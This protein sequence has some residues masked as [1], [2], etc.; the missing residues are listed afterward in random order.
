MERIRK[1]RVLDVGVR[2]LLVLLLMVQA[3][4][5]APDRFFFGAY[6]QK[7]IDRTLDI[8]A[9]GKNL[10]EWRPR[11]RGTQFFRGNGLAQSGVIAVEEPMEISIEGFVVRKKFA[12]DKGLKKPRRMC[13]MPFDRTC[14][15]ASLDH[16]VLRGKIRSQRARLCANGVKIAKH[17]LA[18]VTAS[19]GGRFGGNDAG[20]SIVFG[21][22][23][24]ASIVLSLEKARHSMRRFTIGR[25]ALR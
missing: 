7:L 14:F 13:L 25:C 11:K 2:Q 20:L 1:K 3:K 21:R 9:V 12:Q 18:L 22:F 8:F 17:L 10:G 23:H 6:G 5:D 16:L 24:L 19:R 15:R 4:N